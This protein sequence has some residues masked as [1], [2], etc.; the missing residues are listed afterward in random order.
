[1]LLFFFH[2][3]FF[4]YFVNLK[5]HRNIN[6]RK[7]EMFTR[8]RWARRND[9]YRN[10]Y[11][12]KWASCRRYECVSVFDSVAM[13]RSRA[14]IRSFQFENNIFRHWLNTQYSRIRT[15]SPTQTV[16]T[17]VLIFFSSLSNSE[18]LVRVKRFPVSVKFELF[19]NQHRFF[20]FCVF[21][22]N[23]RCRS[24]KTKV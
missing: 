19:T 11:D 13:C 7:I 23:C 14:L 3:L 6:R 9:M 10:V 21:L 16:Y 12:R 4:P 15:A 8:R 18:C 17:F 5:T 24:R 1:M 2:R 22:V 20:C